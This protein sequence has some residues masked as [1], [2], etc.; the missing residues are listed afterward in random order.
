[1]DAPT[2]AIP[3]VGPARAL[4]IPMHD[5]V[6][7]IERS[8]TLLAGSP[9]GVGDVE[10]VL[11]DD[12]SDDA[13]ADVARA[14]AAR[15]GLRARVV[16]LGRNQGKGA[17]VRTGMLLATA[18]TRVFVDADLSVEIKDI[19]H[20]FEV[21]EGG[22]A[23][24]AY[25]TRA[26][27]ESRLPRSQPAHRVLSGRAYNLLLRRL[28]LTQERDTQ[29]GMKGFSARAAEQVF[30]GLSTAGFG[31]DVE[32]LALAERA[33]WR[34]ESV[35]VTWSHV[36]ASRVRAVRDGVSMG[37]SAIA[38]R[39]RLGRRTRAS[40][41]GQPAAG[42]AP[43]A[44][45]AMARVEREH[46]WFRAKRALVADQIVRFE[47]EDGPLLD[48]GCGT[49]GLLE[50]L[51][52]RRTVVGAELDPRAIGLAARAVGGARLLRASATDLPVRSGGAG[53]VTALDVVEHLDDDVAALRELGRVVAD[54]IGV[55]DG[56]GVADGLVVV[57][58]PAYPWAWSDHDV[59]LGHRRR[60]TRATL[61]A[62]AEAAGLEVLRTT[63]FHSWLAP[64]AFLVRRTVVGRLLRGDA[65]EASFVHPV[66][67][68]AL[69]ALTGVERRVLRHRDLPCGLSILLVARPGRAE[70]PR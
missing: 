22:G 9:L 14:T 20:C 31:F 5:E 49:G 43:Q 33:G 68:R 36:D 56:V 48:V 61:A 30:G 60:Y 46:W 69:T 6:G 32:A 3:A 59:R 11:V 10:L 35:P 70:R 41:G 16:E 8:L 29:C 66:V 25:G 53:V 65:E 51:A 12:G 57:A 44:I 55:A 7:R 37:G 23:D 47:A 39:W 52:D 38:V 24:V 40:V 1:V 62:A 67:N 64:I 45:D 27:P 63:Y 42:M 34:L 4:V 13:T 26:H 54:G 21:L 2:D 17:A 19:L 50:A 58:V 15:L 28:G 18:P